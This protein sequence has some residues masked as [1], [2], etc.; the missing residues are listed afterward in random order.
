MKQVKNITFSRIVLGECQTWCNHFN[1]L[2]LIYHALI[3]SCLIYDNLIC[4]NLVYEDNK[5]PTKM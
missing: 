2:K 1:S 3:Y 4:G 5:H